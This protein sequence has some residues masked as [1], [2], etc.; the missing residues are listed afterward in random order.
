MRGPMCVSTGEKS[1]WESYDEK[2]EMD[3]M[4]GTEVLVVPGGFPDEDYIPDYMSQDHM[5]PCR[6]AKRIQREKGEDLGASWV[7]IGKQN[8]PSRES[9]PSRISARKVPLRSSPKRPTSKAGQRPILPSSRPS[10]A[11][12][13]GPASF[14][15]MRSPMPSPKHESPVS[16]DVQRHMARIRRRELEEDANLKRFNQQLKAMIKEGKEA[17]G[18]KFEVEEVLDV[19]EGYVEGESFDSKCS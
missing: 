13:P 2:Q 9:S 3:R 15:N 11:G 12:S 6:P 5:T 10:F 8:A 17:L 7:M 16:A 18:T 4:N 19:D 14:A 1:I